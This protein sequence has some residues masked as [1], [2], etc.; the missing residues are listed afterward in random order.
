[1]NRRPLVL[2]ALGFVLL[3]GLTLLLV[4][5]DPETEDEPFF[6]LKR[7]LPDTLTVAHGPDTT[8]LVAGGPT[9]WQVI[10]PVQYPA[11]HLVAEA[12]IARLADVRV[13]RVFPLTPEK[14]DTY[15]MRIS[16][17][18]ISASYE[19]GLEPDTLTIGTFTLNDA[20]DYVRSGSDL[21]VGLMDARLVRSFLL[22]STLELRDTRLMPFHETRADTF[23]LLG[24]G[25]RVRV[26]LARDA[27]NR[28][29][30][31]DPFP[32]P[33]DQKKTRNFLTSVGHMNIHRFVTES[34]GG[35]LVDYG[36][37]EPR[38]GARVVTTSGRELTVS[39]GDDLAAVSELPQ[40]ILIAARTGSLPHILGVSQKY[41]PVLA[42]GADAFADPA[43]FHFGLK[44]VER[45]HVAGPT[46]TATFEF[47]D[48]V[49]VPRGIRDVF[50]NW[51]VLRAEAFDRSGD[52]SLARWGLDAPE[53]TLVW[54]GNVDTLAV[55]DVG[56]AADGLR[57]VRVRGGRFARP[58]DI[59]LL[60]E[61]QTGPLWTYIL[62][63]AGLSGS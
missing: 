8:V 4:R 9:G 46:Q 12:M 56:V 16:R 13:A 36:L 43:P 47:G 20:Y 15:G 37:H 45:I 21:E 49:E 51:I 24:P 10:H 42:S 39:L 55:V 53:G 54:V 63:K 31:L 29:E 62:D 33:V 19:G 11:D 14:M 52:D 3:L 5:P 38:V 61:R 40:E 27:E 35:N 32:A 1:M 6:S 17:G 25:D 23:Q 41:L 26:T 28:W 34:E 60:P 2:S 58:D 22:K 59:L 48:S 50:R 44:T 30:L 7:R 57:P 18:R